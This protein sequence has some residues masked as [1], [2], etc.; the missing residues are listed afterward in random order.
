[1]GWNFL[2]KVKS[3]DTKLDKAKKIKMCL[4]QFWNKWKGKIWS[5]IAKKFHKEYWN[6]SQYAK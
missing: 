3:S 2:W 4:N 1:M 5:R 6:D